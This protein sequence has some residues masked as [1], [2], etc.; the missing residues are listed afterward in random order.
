MKKIHPINEIAFMPNTELEMRQGMWVR[1]S[2]RLNDP[3]FWLW[4]DVL[5][6]VKSP[7]IREI[8]GDILSGLRK[9]MVK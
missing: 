8:W 9:E 5:G 3:R 7:S 4:L 6:K 2:A 1:T